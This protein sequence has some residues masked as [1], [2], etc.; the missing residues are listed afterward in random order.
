MGPRTPTG[1]QTPEHVGPRT[2]TGPQTP[3]TPDH[4]GPRTPTGPQTPKTD[5]DSQHSFPNED[6]RSL[7]GLQHDRVT[8]SSDKPDLLNIGGDDLEQ[9]NRDSIDDENG[10]EERKHEGKT[11]LTMEFLC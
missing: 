2:P 3:G 1:P 5:E 10:R 11:I 6:S 4:V 7:D 9:K 8:L